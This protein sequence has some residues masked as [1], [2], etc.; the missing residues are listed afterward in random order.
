MAHKEILAQSVRCCQS[1]C[2]RL[3]GLLGAPK[4][5]E[6][7]A[8]WLVPCNSVHTIGMKYPIDVYFLNKRNEVVG[9]LKN[10]A[11]NRVSRLFWTAHSALELVPSTQ[12]KCRIGDQI[13]IEEN[14]ETKETS[15]Q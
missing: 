12:R 14:H 11:P 4:L 5:H 13:S 8:C 7:E 9:I 15:S 6:M 3:R 2:S 10:M 1:L